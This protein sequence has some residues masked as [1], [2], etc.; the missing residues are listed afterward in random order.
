MTRYLALLRGINVGGKSIIPMAELR[1]LFSDIG[2]QRVST[3]IQ[4]GNVLFDAAAEAEHQ[5]AASVEAAIKERFGED[6]AVI[7][8]T[9]DELDTV[10]AENPFAG[11]QDDVTKLLVAFLAAP[12]AAANAERLVPPAGETGEVALRG[13]EV[14]IHVPD[15]YGRSKLVN[16]FIERVLDVP[17]TTRNWRSINKLRGLL[18]E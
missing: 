13:R 10:I 1:Q 17:C 14:Y 6:V 2:Y 11:R 15:G 4:S 9:I 5:V 3:Y 16:P 8:R 12:P 7:L 18:A